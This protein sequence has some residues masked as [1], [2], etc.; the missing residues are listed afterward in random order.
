[1]P[2]NMTLLEQIIGD[3]SS[4]QILENVYTVVCISPT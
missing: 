2:I 3:D 4:F 1:M